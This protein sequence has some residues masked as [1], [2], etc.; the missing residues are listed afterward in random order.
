VLLIT[1][2]AIFVLFQLPTLFAVNFGMLLA[3]RFLTGFFGS[4][5]LAT[6]GATIADMYRPQ[7]QAYGLAVWGIGAVCGP[8]LGPLVGGFAVEAKGWTWTIWE[9]MWLSGFC[10]IFLFFC[11]PETSATNI[12]HRRTKRLRKL[13]GDDRLTC[14]PDMMSEKMGPKDVSLNYRLLECTY[15]NFM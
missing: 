1:R 8:V 4:P 13:T 6:G 12:L 5:A 10:L 7:K 2:L 9:L 15:A 3:F 11:L 14:E